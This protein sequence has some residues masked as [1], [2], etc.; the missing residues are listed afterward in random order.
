MEEIKNLNNTSFTINVE[1][2]KTHLQTNEK[3]ETFYFAEAI[4]RVSQK[5]LSIPMKV[6]LFIS[7]HFHTFSL[8]YV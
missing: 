3:F 6:R 1:Y 5:S 8:V 7:T 4:R 2:Q